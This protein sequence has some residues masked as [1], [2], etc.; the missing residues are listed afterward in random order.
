MQGK[1][2]RKL[3]TISSY[4]FVKLFGFHMCCKASWRIMQG[5]V[6]DFAEHA[7]VRLL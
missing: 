7:D 6:Q 2:R 3:R 4:W 5:L 1:A